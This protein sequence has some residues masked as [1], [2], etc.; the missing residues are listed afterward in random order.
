MAEPVRIAV[1]GYGLVGRRHAQIVL[2]R[3]ELALAA[4]VEPDGAARAAAAATG[5]AVVESLDA[6]FDGPPVDG[7]ILATPT[8]QHADQGLACIARGL[9]VLIEK[10]IAATAAEGRALAHAGRDAGVP[11][12]VGHHRRHNGTVRAA[13]AA[14]DRGD[15]GAVRAV[16]ATCWVYKPDRYFAAAP[17]R[18]RKGAGPVSVN[19]VHDADLLRHFCGDVVLVQAQTVP[20]R[21]GFENEDLAA[22]LVTF[23]SGALATLSVSDAIAAPWSWELTARENPAYPATPESCYLIGG[24]EGALSLPDLR[25]WR[26]TG[27]PDWWT[28]ISATTLIAGQSDPLVEQALHFAR[29]IRGEE[30]PAVPAEAGLAALEVVEAVETSARTGAAVDIGPG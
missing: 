3:P 17:W 6:L 9:P 5:A 24:S 11:I 2:D 10:P 25:V 18:T 19:L 15:I 13:K 30:A 8:L 23:R 27:A 16:Q 21:R 20:A 26:H 22:A 14:L 4:V 7:V 12:L 28:P 29:V 1:A